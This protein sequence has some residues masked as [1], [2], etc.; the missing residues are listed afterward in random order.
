MFDPPAAPLPT[1]KDFVPYEGDLQAQSAWKNFGGLTLAEAASK[2]RELPD[3]Y[4]EDFM[5]MGGKAFAFYYDVIDDF[6]RELPTAGKGD[7]R[8]AWILAHDIQLQ[9]DCKTTHHVLHLKT[10]VFALAEFV[11]QNI[12]CFGRDADDRQQ[13]AA[14]WTELIEH[15]ASLGTD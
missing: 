6:L 14:V 9:F 2:F 12:H 15:L 8:Q 3:V 10:R 7:D 5:F 13:I 11:L 1:E 4:Q